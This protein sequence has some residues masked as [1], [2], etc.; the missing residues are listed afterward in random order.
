MRILLS[1]FLLTMSFAVLAQ[2]G[3]DRIT[4]AYFNN[5]KDLA[6]LDTVKSLVST[7][8]YGQFISGEVEVYNRQ[9][10]NKNFSAIK[11]TLNK[12]SANGTDD[13]SQCFYPRHSINF[14]KNGKIVKYVLICFECYGLRFS[15]ERWLTKVKDEDKRIKLMDELKAHFLSQKL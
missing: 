12:L 6:L 8:K 4:F 2:G 15:D 3:A 5:P 10:D 11:K 9:S 7:G 14:Y 13:I 1:V